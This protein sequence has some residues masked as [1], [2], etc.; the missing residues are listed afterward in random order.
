ERAHAGDV[1]LVV[2]II[3]VEVAIVAGTAALYLICRRP[4]RALVTRLARRFGLTD[5]RID[6]MTARIERRGGGA[7]TIGRAT[8]GLRTL[9]VVAASTSGMSSRRA[10]AFPVLRSTVLTQ[11]HFSRGYAVG[12]AART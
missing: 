8:P 3:A 10:G 7:L 2:A 5:A 6:R 1:P 11:P 12:S 9:T 4:G